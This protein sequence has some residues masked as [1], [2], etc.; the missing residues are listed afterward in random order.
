[1]A[2]TITAILLGIAIDEGKIGSVNDKVYK[3]LPHFSQG[4]D[5]MLT[6]EHLL[7]MTSGLNWTERFT[8]FNSDVAMAFYSDTLE[9]LLETIHVVRE[10]GKYWKYQCGNT[11]LLGMIISEATGMPLAQYAEEKLWK[12]LGAHHYALWTRDSNGITKAFCC[13][14]ATT[15][16]FALLGRLM[17]NKGKWN[18][19]QI[20]P[21]DYFRKMITP[22]GDA[23]FGKRNYVDFY[24]Y[25]TWLYPRDKQEHIYY[26]AGMYGQYI[27]IFPERNAVMVRNGRMLNQLSI[28]RIPPDLPVYINFALRELK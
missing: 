22:V 12:P 10:P 20:I 7:T 17:L 2:K 27:I 16:D 25:Q 28:M 15:R 3:Y 4:M 18:G 8:D 21:E 14:Y 23:Q 24:G 5:T 26:F 6:I 13:Y 9:G 19:K 11:L 1:M